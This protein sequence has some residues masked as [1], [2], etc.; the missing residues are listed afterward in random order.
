MS[1]ARRGAGSGG[2]GDGA[3]G[4]KIKSKHK[5]SKKKTTKGRVHCSSCKW[6]G[7]LGNL[8]GIF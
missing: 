4:N 6:T 5:I 8:L 2:G 7:S 1:T 3:V